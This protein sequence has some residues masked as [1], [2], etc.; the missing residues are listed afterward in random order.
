MY[1]RYTCLPAGRR[2]P[3]G[4]IIVDDPVSLFCF[5]MQHF[6]FAE[7]AKFLQFQPFRR[8]FFVLVSLIIQIVAN[9]AL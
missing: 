7:F 2:R 3:R 4:I 6:L 8:I 5:F 1:Y 9:S